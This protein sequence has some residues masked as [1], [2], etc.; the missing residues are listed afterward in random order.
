MPDTRV[1]SDEAAPDLH[2]RMRDRRRRQGNALRVAGVLFLVVAVGLGGYVGWLLWGTGLATKRAQSELRPTFESDV[3]SKRPLGSPAGRAGRQ[4]PRQ[5]RGDPRHPEDGPRHGRRG[6][7]RHR[8]A[9][10]RPR[11]LLADRVP[12]GGPRAGRDRRPPDDVRGAVLVARQA[13]GGRPHHAGDR[14]RHLRLP[15][16]AAPHHRRRPRA[17][18]STRRSGPR[19]SSR[20]AT[21]GSP[22]PSAWSCSP[23]A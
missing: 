11:P 22:P 8:V 18:S 16:H 1:S 15:G 13:A 14:V 10:E 2:E 20:R 21:R 6:G 4:G 3:G 9:E 12:V 7:H 23:S 17:G 5:G 19:S